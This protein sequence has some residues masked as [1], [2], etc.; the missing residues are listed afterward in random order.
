MAKKF[1]GSFLRK[2][3]K[4]EFFGHLASGRVPKVAT[5]DGH[6]FARKFPEKN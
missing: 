4:N 3:D 1:P 2:T 5:S 6:D